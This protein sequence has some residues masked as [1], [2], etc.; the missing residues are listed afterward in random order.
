[1]TVPVYWSVAVIVV[2]GIS[3]K[4]GGVTPGMASRVIVV[5]GVAPVAGNTAVT[6]SELT[7]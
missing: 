2:T 1:M 3:P 5:S 4:A 7:A 6:K